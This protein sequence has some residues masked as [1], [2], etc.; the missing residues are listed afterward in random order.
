VTGADL[1][2][3]DRLPAH[4]TDPDAALDTLLDAVGVLYGDALPALAGDATALAQGSARVQTL[5]R[6]L[7]A[8]EAEANG[9]L[10]DAMGDAHD[11]DVEGVGRV[12]RYTPKDRPRWDSDGVLAALL[13]V[14]LVD[15]E[16]GELPSSP[17]EAAERIMA[18]L[19]ECAPIRTPS[20]GWRKTALKAHGLVAGGKPD[21][22]DETTDDGR[23]VLADRAGYLRYVAGTEQVRFRSLEGGGL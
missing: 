14:A 18:V 20:F 13:R 2:T 22:T 4:S 6:H 8:L 1:A 21:E 15:P 3:T 5:V 16:T 12:E 19:G 17:V 11:I 9:M 10:L 23:P 7:R